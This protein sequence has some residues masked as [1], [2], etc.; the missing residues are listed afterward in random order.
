MLYL[1]MLENRP[2]AIHAVWAYREPL[3]EE[4]QVHVI[5]R[6]VVSDLDLGDG[7]KKGSLFKRLTGVRAFSK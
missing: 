2:Y 6:V 3:G 1:G 4:D 7:S 5:N